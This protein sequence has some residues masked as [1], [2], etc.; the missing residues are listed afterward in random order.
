LYD[1]NL[2]HHFE[3]RGIQRQ[4]HDV[5][6]ID[7]EGHVLGLEKAKSKVSSTKIVNPDDKGHFL[8]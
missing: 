7:G 1:K 8:I 6:L 5:G 4:L 3:N 2:R